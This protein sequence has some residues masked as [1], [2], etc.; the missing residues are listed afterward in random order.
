VTFWVT[1]WVTLLCVSP[2]FSCH[3]TPKSRSFYWYFRKF[4]AQITFGCK[5][6]HFFAHIQ[7]NGQKVFDN[8]HFVKSGVKFPASFGTTIGHQWDIVGT[9][10]ALISQYLCNRYP[11]LI[12]S[13]SFRSVNGNR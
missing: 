10:S 4:S 8:L 1:F 6:S 5:V 3:Q 7:G 12:P 11:L 13:I 2:K 9:S